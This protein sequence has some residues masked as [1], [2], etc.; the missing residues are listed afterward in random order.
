MLVSDC[1]DLLDAEKIMGF[2]VFFFP[3]CLVAEKIPCLVAEK[4]NIRQTFF[5]FFY[6]A[7]EWALK[8]HGPTGPV[9]PAGPGGDG[10]GPREK[11]PFSKRI[12]SGLRGLT[13]GSGSDIEKPDPNPTRCHSYSQHPEVK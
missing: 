2:L 6:S 8:Y 3:S 11:N 12:G 4:I 13:R 7:T 1:S 10:S 5:F 9:E